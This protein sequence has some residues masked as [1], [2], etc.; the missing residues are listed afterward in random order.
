VEAS[1]Q[2]HLDSAHL[3]EIHAGENRCDLTLPA[4]PTGNLLGNGD[5]EAGFAAARS[6]EH[7]VEGVRQPWRF[8]FTPGVHC[9]IYPESVYEWRKPRMRSG[10]EAISQVTDGGGTMELYQDVVVN[11]N[12]AL[13]ASAWVL[14]L[15]VQGDG[16]GFGAG[17]EDFAGLV[18]QE[19]DLQDRVLVTHERAGITEATKDFEHVK[20]PFTTRADTAKVRVFL[21]SHIQCIWQKG[22]AL[23][24]ECALEVQ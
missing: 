10:K 7:G 21:T 8:R 20:L 12:Q 11:P 5:F 19:L 4:R 3:L 16:Q 24:D 13:V 2:G 23:L 15:D 22:A 18:V 17:P 14:G 9:Y 6:M 1:K